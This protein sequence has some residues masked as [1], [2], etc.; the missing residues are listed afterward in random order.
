MIHQMNLRIYY[1]DTDAGGIVYHSNY[2]EY[3]ERARTEFLHDIGLSNIDLMERD[4]AFIIKRAEIDYKSPARMED[5][6]TVHTRIG[7]IKNASM[8][9]LQTVKRGDQELVDL[10]IMVVFINP[11]TM[12]P[13]RI[14]ADL[15]E[16]FAQYYTPEGEK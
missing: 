16:K 13:V 4:I 7:E 5:V 11:K 6:L 10:K 1:K 8:I 14:P 3:A 9:M 15:K 12:T 2:L